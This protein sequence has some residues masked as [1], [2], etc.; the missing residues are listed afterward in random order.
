MYTRA[1]VYPGLGT[2][3]ISLF[4]FFFCTPYCDIFVTLL[5]AG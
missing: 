4:F 2:E 1:A 5:V 3:G